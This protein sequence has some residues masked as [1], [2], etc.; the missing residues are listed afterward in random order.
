MIKTCPICLKEFNA[1]HSRNMY[2][3]KKCMGVKYSQSRK[4]SGSPAWKGEAPIRKCKMCGSVIVPLVPGTRLRKFMFCSFECQGRYRS[5]VLIGPKSSM[6]KGGKVEVSCKICDRKFSVFPFVIRKGEGNF[7]S[8]SCSSINTKINSKK[9]G[10]SIEIKMGLELTRRGIKFSTQYPIWKAKTIPDFLINPNICIYC[11]GDYW[12][13]LPENKEKDAK[14]NIMLS[15]LG[16]VVY[17]FWEHEINSDIK[18][19]VDSIKG[20]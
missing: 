15:K 18:K 2:C 5:E 16:Y 14:Q 17:R 12:H 7:C 6:W 8:Q 9:S 11:D 19:C 4:G 10:T 13:N 3:S 20:I 1:T